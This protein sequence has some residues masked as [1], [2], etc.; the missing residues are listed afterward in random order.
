[1]AWEL[2][3]LGSARKDLKRLDPAQRKRI[4]RYLEEQL[5]PQPDPRVLGKPLTGPDFAGIWRFRVGD[6]RLLCRFKQEVV[7]VVLLHVEHR[8]SVYERFRP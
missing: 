8:S 4:Y 1:M 3:I 5:L 7:V 6:Y 2:E